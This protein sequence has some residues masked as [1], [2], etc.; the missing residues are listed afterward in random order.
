M[1]SADLVRM[2]NQIAAYYEAYP[3]P[4]AIDGI[5]KHVHSFWEPRMRNALKDYLDKGG[6]GLSPLFAEAAHEYF[7]GPRK[8]S[9][10][11]PAA[12]PA[13]AGATPSVNRGN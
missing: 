5:K 8:P 3:K 10:T 9:S 4:E 13:K 7:R 2:A 1:Q 12:K 11:A 6:E